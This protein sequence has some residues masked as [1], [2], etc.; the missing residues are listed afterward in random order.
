M[1]LKVGTVINSKHLNLLKTS[2]SKEPNRE[3]KIGPPIT[4]KHHHANVSL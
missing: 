3:K 4:V 2:C 1:Q